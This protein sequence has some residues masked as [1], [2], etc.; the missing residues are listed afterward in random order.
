[1]PM[2]MQALRTALTIWP[3]NSFMVKPKPLMPFMSGWAMSSPSGWWLVSAAAMISP[4]ANRPTMTAS[5]SKPPLR[6]VMPK[7]K[8]ALLSMTSV[9]TVENMKPITPA[10][11]PLIMLPLDIVAIMVREKMAME[12]NSKEPKLTAARAICGAMN[13]S[14]TVENT[15]PIKLNT[16]PTPSA[17]AAWPLRTIGWPSK[18]VATEDGVPGMCSRMAEIRPPEIAPMNSAISMVMALEGAMA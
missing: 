2:P 9:P 15:V 13:M 10:M 8:R 11:M 16:T 1:M 4:T 14:S 12:K 3:R 17:L 7:L 5:M 6:L 18:Q